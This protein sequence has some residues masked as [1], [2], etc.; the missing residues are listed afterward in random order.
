MWEGRLIQR[1]VGG[2][3]EGMYLFRIRSIIEIFFIAVII[4]QIPRNSDK[5]TK[6]MNTKF[7]EIVPRIY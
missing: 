4:I 5:L 6:Y 3:A 1:D 2:S 7:L